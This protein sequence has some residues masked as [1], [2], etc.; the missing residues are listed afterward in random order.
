MAY[1]NEKT[2]KIKE[3]VG[4]IGEMMGKKSNIAEIVPERM[5]KDKVIY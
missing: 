2:L 4:K 1:I 3:L 5:G